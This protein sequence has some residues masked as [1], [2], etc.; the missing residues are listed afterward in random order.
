MLA[1]KLMREKSLADQVKV[2]VSPSHWKQRGLG[3]DSWGS[4]LGSGQG[5]C[6]TLGKPLS[7]QSW[8]SRLWGW[9]GP[10]A[11]AWSRSWG[12]TLDP[13]NSMRSNLL[14]TFLWV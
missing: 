6:V 14:L 12:R 9:V 8:L 1:D 13:G 5:C 2:T 4:G 10:E 11:L 7:P 3:V